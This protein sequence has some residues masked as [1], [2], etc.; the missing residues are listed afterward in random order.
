MVFK[1]L[2]LIKI[3]RLLI[4]SIKAHVDWITIN[5][6]VYNFIGRYCDNTIFL[7]TIIQ[8][9]TVHLSWIFKYTLLQA[10]LIYF[11][12]FNIIKIIEVILIY[13]RCQ[14]RKHALGC[15]SHCQSRAVIN[16]STCEVVGDGWKVFVTCAVISYACGEKVW[17]S[18]ILNLRF[19]KDILRFWKPWFFKIFSETFPFELKVLQCLIL[20][21][22]S[23]TDSIPKS[24]REFQG[25]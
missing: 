24:K 7:N 19:R 16:F 3:S 5:L 10:L 8:K 17:L 1:N 6:L 22:H 25:G 15:S 13:F 11:N 14:I 20:E 4:S 2:N 12:L 23:A 18:Q 21:F 9:K